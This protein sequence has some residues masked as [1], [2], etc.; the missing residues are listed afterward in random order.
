MVVAVAH[1]STQIEQPL[2][3]GSECFG[4]LGQ[5][6]GQRVQRRSLGVR[7]RTD[8]AFGSHRFDEAI[9]NVRSRVVILLVQVVRISERYIATHGVNRKLE[10]N[11]FEWTSTGIT[12][13]C[14]HEGF[15]IQV[16]NRGS[17][18]G[19]R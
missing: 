16:M 10:G 13:Y 9:G 14:R 8:G 19:Q 4:P 12:R 15:E 5:S 3:N 7:V 18:L 11:G 2:G 6:R 1:D 17:Q